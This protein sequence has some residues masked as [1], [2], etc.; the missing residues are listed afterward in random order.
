M[1]GSVR[2]PASEPAEVRMRNRPERLQQNRTLWRS[3]AQQVGFSSC[4]PLVL[5]CTLRRSRTVRRRR[6]CPAPLHPDPGQTQNL[7]LGLQRQNVRSR[8]SAEPFS[9]PV[10]R[11]SVLMCDVGLRDRRGLQSLQLRGRPVPASCCCRSGGGGEPGGQGGT[12]GASP[13]WREQQITYDVDSLW[14]VFGQNRP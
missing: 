1:H 2:V 7:L 3:S 13:G 10:L 12:V 9:A 14:K 8:V 11:I 5:R 6:V 4:L